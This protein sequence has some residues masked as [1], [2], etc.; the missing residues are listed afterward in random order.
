MSKYTGAPHILEMLIRAPAGS[1]VCALLPD[2][3]KQKAVFDLLAPVVVSRGG[4]CEA[5]SYTMRLDGA[6]LRLVVDSQELRG[7]ELSTVWVDEWVK[8]SDAAYA[9]MRVR[10]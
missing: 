1:W 9:R 7:M 8:E 6:N 5:S 4:T 10:S 3:A 2:A